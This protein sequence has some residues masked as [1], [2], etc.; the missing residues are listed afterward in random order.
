[1]LETKRLQTFPDW[2]DVVARNR[3]SWQHQLGN[4]VP[5]RLAEIV[6]DPLSRALGGS[7]ADR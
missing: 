1:M 2:Y 6:A 4:A 7:T 5:P 3:R